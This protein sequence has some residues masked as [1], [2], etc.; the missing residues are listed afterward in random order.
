MG[1]RIAQFRELQTDLEE[2]FLSFARPGS[3]AIGAGSVAVAGGRRA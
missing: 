2:A 1:L 3:E